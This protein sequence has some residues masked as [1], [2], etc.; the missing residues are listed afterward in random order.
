MQQERGR[1]FP[2]LSLPVFVCNYAAF[3][4]PSSKGLAPE[5]NLYGR[6]RSEGMA[7]PPTP[8]S[9]LKHENH[10]WVTSPIHDTPLAQQTTW[11]SSGDVKLTVP[12]ASSASSSDHSPDPVAAAKEEKLHDIA[13]QDVE[14]EAVTSEPFDSDSET[15]PP[16]GMYLEPSDYDNSEQEQEC[17]SSEP[18]AP[19]VLRCNWTDC[20]KTLTKS[21]KGKVKVHT[22]PTC[23]GY[24]CSRACRSQHRSLKRCPF[25]RVSNICQ[26]VLQK[27]RHDPISRHQLSLCAQRG[28][29]SRG[30]GVIRLVFQGPQRAAQFLESGWET[31]RGQMFYV[32]RN[33]LLPHDM[34]PRVYAR[35]RSLCDEYDPERKFVLLVAVCVTQEVVTP[36]GHSAIS[37]E[38]VVKAI[39]LRLSGPLPEEDV[40]TLILPVVSPQAGSNGLLPQHKQRLQG[41]QHV[42][43]QLEMRGV[44]LAGSYPELYVKIRAFVDS[45]ELFSP[46][47]TFPTD[48]RTGQMFMCIVLPWA[49]QELLDRMA[50]TRSAA[51]VKSRKRWIL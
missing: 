26:E 44:D 29:L 50:G 31:V 15:Q 27:I 39:K 37:R 22:C 43:R 46:V 4:S 21:G 30:R 10:Q 7:R 13:P 38:M 32:A 48:V 3:A 6:R 35:I 20:Q 23:Y 12:V 11:S 36:A 14:L 49:D 2:F 47:C 1:S 45:G 9:I 5:S 24:F 16:L 34:G 19:A 18:A 17:A 41:L 42:E 33:D 8:I 51:A 25:T 40:Q 28:L